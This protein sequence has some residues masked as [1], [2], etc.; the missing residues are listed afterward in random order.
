MDVVRVSVGGS[1]SDVEKCLAFEQAGPVNQ[2]AEDK[3]RWEKIPDCGD[4]S[5][6]HIDPEEATARLKVNQLMVMNFQLD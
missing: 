5:F 4:K 1:A 3:V 6:K 2:S